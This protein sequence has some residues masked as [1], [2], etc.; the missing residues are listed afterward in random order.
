MTTIDL[1]EDGAAV[2][3]DAL[4]TWREQAYRLY[5]PEDV[6]RY[7]AAANR[8]LDQIDPSSTPTT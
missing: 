8:V 7:I 1:D 2:L 3:L 4:A 6:E 5:D